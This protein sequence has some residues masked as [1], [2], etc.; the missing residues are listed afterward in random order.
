MTIHTL[1]P[2]LAFAAL[3]SILASC[4]PGISVANKAGIAKFRVPPTSGSHVS[5]SVATMGGP[6]WEMGAVPQ[7]LLE[8]D[9]ANFEKTH[10]EGLRS[11]AANLPQ[12]VVPKVDR[13][14]RSKLATTGRVV[15]S[16]GGILRVEVEQVG[17]LSPPNPVGTIGSMVMNPFIIAK[18]TLE[19]SEG[20]TVVQDRIIGLGETAGYKGVSYARQYLKGTKRKSVPFLHPK[21]GKSASTYGANPALLRRDF[22]SAVHSLG[23]DLDVFLKEVY[24]TP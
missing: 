13:K 19:D 1:L 14:L 24:A 18:V 5:Y 15:Q 2:R 9:R 6:D 7:L 16:G 22:D 4:A 20:R 11:I 8:I 10:G 12:D 23:E 17:V 21:T 3:V